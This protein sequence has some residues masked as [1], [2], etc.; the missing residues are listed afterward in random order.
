MQ[1]YRV[2][3]GI[4]VSKEAWWTWIWWMDGISNVFHPD[5]GAWDGIRIRMRMVKWSNWLLRIWNKCG[6]LS[7]SSLEQNNFEPWQE[8]P[9]FKQHRFLLQWTRIGVGLA[10]PK[11]E[12]VITLE[13]NGLN[14]VL[15]P[16]LKQNSMVMVE[17][18]L[19]SVT[20]MVAISLLN[21]FGFA[22]IMTSLYCYAFIFFISLSTS[23]CW[24]LFT[25]K[26]MNVSWVGWNH[27]LWYFYY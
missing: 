25:F 26:A 13:K 27:I 19:L 17:S 8:R 18:I 3:R 23:W 10:I 6:M 21:S 15:S 5:G 7:N 12:L 11:V 14:D 4:S 2:I 1:W 16:W 20:A 22:W 24:Y 9:Q